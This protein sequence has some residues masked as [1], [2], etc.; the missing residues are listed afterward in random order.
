MSEVYF[1]QISKQILSSNSS[2]Q[3][4]VDFQAGN[5]ELRPD[6]FVSNQGKK[7]LSKTAKIAI[8]IGGIATAGVAA[9]LLHKKINKPTIEKA[10]KAFQEI[11]VR[12]D[13]SIKETEAI[14]ARY[15][16]I[17][18]IAN[19]EEYIQAL[20]A[21]AK[22]NFGL[23]HTNISLKIKDLGKAIGCSDGVGNLT[24]SS[25]AKRKGMVNFIHHELRHSKQKDIMASVDMDRL[26]ESLFQRAPVQKTLK[27]LDLYKKHYDIVKQHSPNLSEKQVSE[28]A[29]SNV[30]DHLKKGLLAT[31]EKQGLGKIKYENL[32]D[33][34]VKALF[35]AEENYVEPT[36]NPIGYRFNFLEKDARNAGETTQKI[37]KFFS[38]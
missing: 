13:I 22:K 10:Q 29:M 24:I 27:K 34:F 38:K 3:R 25:K 14:L 17:E 26:G 30:I 33:D 37:V 23:E 18:K 16:E 4:F 5:Y 12:D 21:F 9:I 15:K 8:A 7:R 6:T 31:Y 19:D 2:P 35:K 36:L 32:D 28:V 11:F 20:F 1:N